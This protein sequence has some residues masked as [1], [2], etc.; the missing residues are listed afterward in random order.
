[1]L[2]LFMSK[3]PQLKPNLWFHDTSDLYSTYSFA[4]R[5][6]V[7]FKE[8]TP[9]GQL[10]EIYDSFEYGKMLVIDGSTQSTEGDEIIYHQ[11][12]VHPAGMFL[13]YP[14]R[15]AL[16][17]GGGEG[18]TLR[19]MLR[20]QGVECVVMVDADQRVVQI[21]QEML[22]GMWQEAHK[23]PRSQ[24]V[25]ADALEY[26]HS[27]STFYRESPLQ[28]DLIISDIT[29]PIEN[30]GTSSHL[31]TDEYYELICSRLKADGV[32]VMQSQELSRTSFDDHKKN[33][34][35]L[36][37]FLPFVFTYRQFIPSFAYEQ[38]FL[39]AG[40]DSAAFQKMEAQSIDQRIHDRIGYSLEEYSG[41]IHS[42]IF[43]LPP[44]LK[45]QLGIH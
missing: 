3:N 15:S 13:T 1:M 8:K 16:I 42:S 20:Y 33:R 2:A 24:I 36:G 39:L 14:P 32:F 22:P 19:E 34:D 30:K 43:A 38:S 17:L 28:F 25:I 9:T 5:S 6:P 11:L 12:L 35:R 18:A 44:F 29:D 4:L 26:L 27:P 40:R 21:T 10:V 37:K 7:L 45:K 23:D 41:E 31:Y